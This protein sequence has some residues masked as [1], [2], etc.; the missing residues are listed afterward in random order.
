[1]PPTEPHTIGV[2]IVARQEGVPRGRFDFPTTVNAAVHLD[3][4]RVSVS[5]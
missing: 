5:A 3:V 2:G 4:A 1:M